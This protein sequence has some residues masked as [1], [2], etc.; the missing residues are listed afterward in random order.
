MLMEGHDVNRGLDF[1]F[2]PYLWK[3]FALCA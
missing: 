3:H 2:Q 1:S